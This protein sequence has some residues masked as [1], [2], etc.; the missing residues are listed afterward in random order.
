MR[1]AINP[2]PSSTRL[3]CQEGSA[4]VSGHLIKAAGAE[5]WRFRAAKQVDPYQQEHDD[6][7]AAIRSNTEH[8]EAFNGAKSSLTAIMGRMATYS[9]KEVKW[10]IYNTINKP[11]VEKR[12]PVAVR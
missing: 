1:T 3:T 11:G 8:N 12:Q 9:G 4:D 5:S 7:F 6:L 10:E 2:R